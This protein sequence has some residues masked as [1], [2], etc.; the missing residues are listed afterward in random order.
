M[1]DVLRGLDEYVP[2]RPQ[3]DGTYFSYCVADGLSRVLPRRFS[4]WLALRAADQF[5][6]RDAVG[7]AGVIANLRRIAEFK[8]E[9]L[10]DAQVLTMARWTFRNFGKHVADFF[11]FRRLSRAGLGRILS[12]DHPERLQQAA[13]LGRGVMALT[14][15]FGSWELGAVILATR[16]YKVNVVVLPQR[17]GRIDALF[18]RRREERGSRV[19]PLGR[20]ARHVLEALKRRE[21]VALL[22]DQDY[23]AQDNFATFFGAPAR[24]PG[25]PAR[26]C[27]R[28]GA[29][30]VPGFVVRRPDDTF[31]A[32]I[33]PPI[34]PA[35]GT[36][37]SD[38]QARICAAIEQEIAAAPSQ[39]FIFRDFWLK[40]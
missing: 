15:H 34:V 22:G 5:F 16:G 32:H 28:T 37:E 17:D 25:G 2:M 9:H 10:S 19:V 14:A 3:P 6:A 24:L 27:V 11:R 1:P 36:V 40:T 4:Y 38:V 18:Q 8:G 39:W 35:R 26:L 23:T 7:R 20:A 12:V 13:D 29:P 30:I 31:E 33:H 21:F